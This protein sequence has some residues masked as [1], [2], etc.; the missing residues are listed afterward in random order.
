MRFKGLART[1]TL[2]PLL[3]PSLLSAISL[4][5]WFG[6]QGVL[7][8]WLTAL[9]IEQIYGAPGIVLAEIFST[10]PHALMILITALTAADARLYEAA[11]A[12]G[13]NGARKFF[14]ITL[15]GAKYGLISAALVTFTLVDHRLRHPEGDRR[16]LQR[17]RHRRL[18]ARHRPAGF[19]DAARWSRCCCWRRRC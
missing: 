2:V 5:Y 15:P 13:T 19:P 7:K 8:S 4:I 1:I 9:G 11:D 16:Q 12:M 6:N 18:Q 10:F 14:T 3:A 17:A